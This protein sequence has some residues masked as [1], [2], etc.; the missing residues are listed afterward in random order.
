MVKISRDT[1]LLFS[2]FDYT[3]VVL[4][5]KHLIFS[6]GARNQA[7]AR[8]PAIA[9]PQSLSNR[10]RRA[11][12]WLKAFMKERPILIERIEML[13]AIVAS[14]LS[15]SAMTAFKILSGQSDRMVAQ[16]YFS[17]FRS[18]VCDGLHCCFARYQSSPKVALRPFC[19]RFCGF[20]SVIS[21]KTR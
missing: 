12:Q 19:H 6:N 14:I 2:K 9:D 3:V 5:A 21:D 18:Q 11:E 17:L 4:K 8:R 13:V 1:K 16:P 15:L 7:I 10:E 20:W